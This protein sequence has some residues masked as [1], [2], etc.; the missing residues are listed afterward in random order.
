MQVCGKLHEDHKNIFIK[1]FLK[2]MPLGTIAMVHNQLL[3][4]VVD[5]ILVGN[6]RHLNMEQPY[7][8]MI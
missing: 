2:D 5:C 1:G 4:D 6:T 7:S 8:S 3:P